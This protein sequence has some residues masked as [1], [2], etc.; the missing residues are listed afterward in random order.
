MRDGWW[1]TAVLVVAMACAVGC[2]DRESCAPVPPS[3]ECPDLKFRG[4]GYVEFRAFDAPPPGQMQEVGNATYP[5]CNVVKGCPGSEFEGLGATDVWLLDGVN[6]ADAVIGKR[7]NSQA[8]VI[9]VRVGVEP[10]QLPIP[11]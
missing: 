9:F 7:Q 4:A 2:A 6:I 3:P 8:F 1:R 5:D 11:G 10:D